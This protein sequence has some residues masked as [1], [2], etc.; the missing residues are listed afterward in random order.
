MVFIGKLLAAIAALLAG[1]LGV[2]VSLIM[3]L[4]AITDIINFI[5]EVI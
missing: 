3:I 5:K 2:P 4:W 1:P